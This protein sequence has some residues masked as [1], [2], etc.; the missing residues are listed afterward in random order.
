M[1][2]NFSA[3]NAVLMQTILRAGR[4]MNLSR[5]WTIRRDAEI[6]RKSDAFDYRYYGEQIANKNMRPNDLLLH[7]L[8]TGYKNNLQPNRI[9]NTQEYLALN[10]DVSE[11]KYEP[12]THYIKYG[13]KEGRRFSHLFSNEKYMNER[14]ITSVG[15]NILSY[16]VKMSDNAANDVDNAVEFDVFMKAS[17]AGY[18]DI[19]WYRK[20]YSVGG[21]SDFEVFKDYLRKSVFSTVLPSE[22]FSGE[23]YL[24]QHLDVY[25]NQ[26]PPLLHYVLHGEHE[27]RGAIGDRVSSSDMP[28]DLTQAESREIKSLKVAFQAHIYYDDYIE[29]I[30]RSLETYPVAVDLYITTPSQAV[31]TSALETFSRHEKVKQVDV[32]ISANTGRNFGP[33][34]VEHSKKLMEYDLVCHLHSK[35][36]LYSGRE[37]KQWASYL[38]EYLVKD[39]SVV[40]EALRR[41]V[42]DE[43]IGL[44]YPDTFFMMPNWVNHVLKNKP[45]MN[46]L[47]QEFGIEKFDDFLAYPAGGMFWFRPPA[48]RQLLEKEFRYTDFPAEPLANDGTVLHAIERIIV[49]LAQK[50]G[51]KQLTYNPKENRFSLTQDFIFSSYKESLIDVLAHAANHQVISF[52]LFDTLLMREYTVAD[53]A[54]LKMGK[55]LFEERRIS[56]PEEFVRV[57][58]RI[59]SKLRSEQNFVGDVSI[60]EIYERLT[61]ELNIQDVS[62]SYLANLEFEHDLSMIMAK[63]EMVDYFNSLCTKGKTV[64]II[65]DTYY[66]AKQIDLIAKRIGLTGEYQLFVSSELKL[67][68]DNGTMWAMIKEKIQGMGSPSYIHIGDS[69]VS[70]AQ[71]PGDFGI[72]SVH[73]LHPLDKW[74]A[75]GFNDVLGHN[76][77]DESRILKWGKLVSSAGRYPWL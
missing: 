44:Y 5:M 63:T 20:A 7:Y 54:K 67:R 8:T 16:Y 29:A 6:I 40:T 10:P 68:K 74:K 47:C 41:F 21:G 34:L 49:P 76:E 60:T 50:N 11:S 48:L 37:Q 64:W 71:V 13:M 56:S 39:S 36:S 52:D 3:F 66:T 24:K 72:N 31:Q 61:T 45:Y 14:N 58:N 27:G 65:T 28:A 22:R 9:F 1:R 57:R 2:P 33:L 75:L 69:V 23:R 77:L 53:F 35:K 59:E 51:Y 46:Q 43:T 12:F 70:D 17:K 62:A 19:E 4:P 15:D 73:L 18:F 42:N 26:M 30:S 25:H 38:L 55:I 32:A